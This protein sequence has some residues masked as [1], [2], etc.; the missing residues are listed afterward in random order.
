MHKLHKPF[1]GP[2]FFDKPIVTELPVKI[3]S[4]RNKIFILLRWMDSNIRAFGPLSVSNA[5]GAS[6]HK[7]MVLFRSPSASLPPFDLI[8]QK[9]GAIPL[10]MYHKEDF[11]QKM[12]SPRST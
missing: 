4:Q 3:K 6:P 12:K 11:T 7:I 2:T 9:A 1:E 5:Y 8:I 10:E